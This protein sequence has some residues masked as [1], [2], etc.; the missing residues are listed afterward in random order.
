VATT[1]FEPRPLPPPVGA[2]VRQRLQ[3]AHQLEPFSTIDPRRTVRRVTMLLADL[4]VE[5]VVYRGG[6]DLRGTEVDHVW[7]AVRPAGSAD[8]GP[9][10]IDA[11]FPLFAEDFVA[12]L[13]RFVAGDAD[14]DELALAAARAGVEQRVL[15][16]F[17][18]PLRYLGRPVWTAS[19]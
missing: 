9:Y 15:G 18:E 8:T 14:T 13:R 3:A 6:V 5:S 10:V 2:D 12:T 7:L 17:P 19:H 1:V 16:A 11:A 4:V